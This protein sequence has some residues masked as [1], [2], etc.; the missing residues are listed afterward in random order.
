MRRVVNRILAARRAAGFVV[1]LALAGCASYEPLAR[2]DSAVPAGVTLRDEGRVIALLPERAGGPAPHG[3][4]FYPGGLV[5]PEA[6]VE[7]LAPLAA[8]GIPVALLRVPADLAV[9]APNRARRVLEG[10]IGRAA[11]KWTVAGHSLGGAMAARFVARRS[12]EYASVRGLVMLA[13]YP[14]RSDSLAAREIPVLSVW[15]SED[16]LATAEDRRQ[17][18]SLIPEDARVEVISGGNHAGF[19]SYGPQDGD[20]EASIPREEQHQRTRELIVAF[21]SSL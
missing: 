14:A 7:L 12:D 3:V 21:L 16:G 6:Y 4:I 11:E 1:L 15:A 8:D 2:A 9:L 20:G 17:T 10:E 13:G 19:G 5:E 18:R